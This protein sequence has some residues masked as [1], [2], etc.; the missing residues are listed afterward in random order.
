MFSL[1]SHN[2][3]QRLALYAFLLPSILLLLVFIIP[4]IDAIRLSLTNEA[5]IGRG[6]VDPEFVGLE[7]FEIMFADPN[8]YNSLKVTGIFL[9]FSAL[10]GQFLVGL[11]A[12]MVMKSR[13]LRFR[14]IPNAAIILP[15]AVPETVAAFMWASMLVPNE[16]GT[17]NLISSMFGAEAV[18][19]IR[20]YPLTSI[21]VINIWR[22][23]GFAFI[24]FAAALE[25]IPNDVVEA[26]ELDGATRFD[27]FR[28]ITLPFLAPTIL[29]FFL[30]TTVGTI[31]VFGL[32][33]FLTA[34]GP[35]RATEI[36]GIYIYSESFQYYELGYGAAVGV[37]MLLFS[38]VLGVLYLRVL[39]VKV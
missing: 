33:Y 26:A 27:M 28:Y 8:F 10:I 30:L 20:H 6:Y 21:I 31:G 1:I 29:V 12:A 36:I 19:W 18:N 4:T 35:A 39:K 38:I 34:G 25:A 22:G 2:Q 32:I 9:L 7:N 23:M 15:L 3:R 17:I 5:L 11:F 24:L 16:T 14:A 13:S 37:I